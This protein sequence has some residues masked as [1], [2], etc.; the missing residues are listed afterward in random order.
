MLAQKFV[1]RH[2]DGAADKNY[3]KKVRKL[4]RSKFYDN[5]IVSLQCTLV[6]VIL[7]TISS[8]QFPV[9]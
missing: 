2:I 8:K 1:E 3:F 7:K 4:K 6:L 5:A 9:T